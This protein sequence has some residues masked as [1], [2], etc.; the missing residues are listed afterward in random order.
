MNMVS[1]LRNLILLIICLFI[2]GCFQLSSEVT[3]TNQTQYYFA[4]TIDGAYT[5]YVAN[6]YSTVDVGSYSPGMHTFYA[7]T[8][9][10]TTV[11][12]VVGPADENVGAIAFD[13]IIN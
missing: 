4:I 10:P 8:V 7:S 12:R 3:I 13:W 5:G 2:A 11:N 6:P 9:A 1:S